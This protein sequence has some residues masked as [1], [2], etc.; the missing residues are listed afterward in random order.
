MT[1][2]KD[3]ID[4]RGRLAAA[5]RKGAK[6]AAANYQSLHPE[7]AKFRLR[8]D[9]AATE[10]RPK[11]MRGYA[12]RAIR[13]FLGDRSYLAMS[14]AA[15]ATH[16]S[17]NIPGYKAPANLLTERFSPGD[18]A[19]VVALLKERGIVMNWAKLDSPSKI[20]TALI[21]FNKGV[22]AV[23]R[24]TVRVAFTADSVVINDRAYPMNGQGRLQRIQIGGGKLNVATLR[25]L[26]CP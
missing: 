12:V 5:S 15:L 20:K 4:H 8:A 3:Q 7:A 19:K 11:E 26:L 14:N 23:E 13:L 1:D 21:A 2:P 9:I 16:L 24:A 18:K 25:A 22:A 10:P 17:A 6:D